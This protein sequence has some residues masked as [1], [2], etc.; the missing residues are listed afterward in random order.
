MSP[1]LPTAPVMGI[2]TEIHAVDK[3]IE[4]VENEISQVEAALNRKGV[5]LGI[6]DPDKLFMVLQQLRDKKKQLRDKEKQLRDEMLCPLPSSG[7][8]LGW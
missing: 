7:K 2:T 3:G 6:S 8:P 1:R 5:Y 4:E